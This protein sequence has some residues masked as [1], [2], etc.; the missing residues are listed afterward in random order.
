M[1]RKNFLDKNKDI[2]LSATLSYFWMIFIF[3]LDIPFMLVKCLMKFNT[4]DSG[5]SLSLSI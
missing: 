3:H 5:S 1:D 4:L 2:Y